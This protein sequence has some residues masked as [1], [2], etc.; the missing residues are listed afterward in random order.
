LP[1]TPGPKARAAPAPAAAPP[2]RNKPLLF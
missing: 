2:A 1:N